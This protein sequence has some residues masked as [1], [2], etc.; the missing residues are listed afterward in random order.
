[1]VYKTL[2]DKIKEYNKRDAKFYGNMFAKWRKLEHMETR[3]M[4][5]LSL[6]QPLLL[7]APTSAVDGSHTSLLVEQLQKVPG[8]QE[9]QPMD[10]DSAA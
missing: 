4:F 10:I 9:A 2:K 7:L 1:M 8:K 5:P 3:G 6:V